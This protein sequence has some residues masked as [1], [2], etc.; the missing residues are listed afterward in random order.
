MKARNKWRVINSAGP[1]VYLGL[2]D[3]FNIQH[4]LGTD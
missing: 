4:L 3:Y 1:V 2:Y